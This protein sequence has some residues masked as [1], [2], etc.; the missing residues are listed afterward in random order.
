MLTQEVVI[1]TCQ[2]RPSSDVLSHLSIRSNQVYWRI[3]KVFHRIS[4]NQQFVEP[5]KNRIIVDYGGI[6][7]DEG[8]ISILS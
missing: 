3:I 5:T 6:I 4:L 1:S 2:N 8:E 7:V